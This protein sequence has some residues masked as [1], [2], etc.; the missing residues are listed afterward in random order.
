[1]KFLQLCL[2]VHL[3][4]VLFVALLSHILSVSKTLSNCFF[5]LFVRHAF[6]VR[7]SKALAVLNV[8]DHCPHGVGGNFVSI[9]AMTIKDAH[10]LYFVFGYYEEV[11]LVDFLASTFSAAELYFLVGKLASIVFLEVV[12][13]ISVVENGFRVIEKD[14]FLQFF[15]RVAKVIYPGCDEHVVVSGIQLLKLVSIL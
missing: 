7:F 3:Q 14:L 4:K 5:N 13:N 15:L 10:V 9:D 11:V 2:S 6:D 12:E 1:V 8:V